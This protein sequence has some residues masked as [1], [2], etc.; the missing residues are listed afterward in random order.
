M[1]AG[2]QSTQGGVR[3]RSV[4]KKT[5]HDVPFGPD[6]IPQISLAPVEEV[7]ELR[8]ESH[9][10]LRLWRGVPRRQHILEY[11]QSPASDLDRTRSEGD[12]PRISSSNPRK[13]TSSSPS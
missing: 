7:R 12:I 8:L 11:S 2:E 9:R 1:Y 3:H 13:T 10:G 5:A 6:H 4:K